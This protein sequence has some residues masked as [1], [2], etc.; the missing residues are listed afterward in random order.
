LKLCNRCRIYVC[1]VAYKNQTVTR[2]T[3]EKRKEF[4][5]ISPDWIILYD[6]NI[7]GGYRAS[8]TDPRKFGKNWC[9]FVATTFFPCGT[10]MARPIFSTHSGPR[11]RRRRGAVLFLSSTIEGFL[12][13]L[14]PTFSE[15]RLGGFQHQRHRIFEC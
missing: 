13:P 11:G 14:S 7:V 8:I 1:Q 9:Y 2:A 4:V 3:A 6:K 12:R 15:H 10:S 5:D